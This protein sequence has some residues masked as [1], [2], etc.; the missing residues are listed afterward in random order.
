MTSSGKKDAGLAENPGPEEIDVYVGNRLRKRRTLMGLSQTELAEKVGVT[1]QQLQ[2]YEQGLNR[3]G[4]SRLFTIALALD[5]DITYFFEGIRD[6]ENPDPPSENPKF[7]PTM[8]RETL[9]LVRAFERIKDKSTRSMIMEMI[10][11]ILNTQD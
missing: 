2:K 6:Q 11:S 1:F 4:S 3:I 5:T 9:E 10:K 7:D 8:T